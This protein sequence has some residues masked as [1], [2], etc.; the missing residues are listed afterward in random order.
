[1]NKNKKCSN[2][3]ALIEW[4]E[5]YNCLKNLNVDIKLI[6]P[7]KGFPDLTYVD[8][9]LLFGNIFIP[10]N[11][12]NKERQGEKQINIEWF[13]NNNYIIKEIDLHP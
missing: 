6:D 5:L 9:G 10:S 11:F 7:V 13:K 8:A 12:Y 3:N 2:N 1:M 4:I